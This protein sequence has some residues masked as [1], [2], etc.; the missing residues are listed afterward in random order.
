MKS[1]N[2]NDRPSPLMT[3]R[4]SCR[5][6]LSLMLA[7]LCASCAGGQ[8][9]SP[10]P[11]GEKCLE[12]GNTA[13]PFTLDPSRANLVTESTILYDM[14]V[15]LTTY[16]GKGRTVPGM[17]V[18]WTTSQD[19]LTWTFTLRKANWSDGVPVTATDFVTAFR[20]IQDPA[21]ASPYSY[22]YYLIVGTEAVNAGKARPETIGAFAPSPQTLVLKLTHPAPYLA[23]LLAHSSALPLPRHVIARWGDKWVEPAHYVT[24]GAYTLQFWK[25]GDRIVLRKNPQFVD[26]HSVCFDQVSYY[27]TTDPVSA[28]RRVASG[29]LDMINYSVQSRAKYRSQHM[30]GYDRPNPILSTYYVAFNLQVPQLTDRRVRLALSMAIDREFMASKLLGA[31]VTPL[32][33][34]TPPGLP[35]YEQ[36]ATPIWAAWPFERRIAA[37][38]E[39][40]RRVGYTADHPLTLEFKYATSGGRSGIAALQAD[41][42]RI[43]ADISLAPAELQI[44]YSELNV[45]AY[46]IALA[47]WTADYADASTYLDL[48][49]KSSGQQ[50]YTGYDNPAYAGLAAQATQERDGQKRISILRRSEAL[51]MADWPV[52]PLYTD[53][54]SYL[55][56]PRITGFTPNAAD[57]HL[58]RYMCERPR[59]PASPTS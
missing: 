51:A 12:V 20:R 35:G 41:W 38:Q 39:L 14:M 32:Y 47:G 6:W 53:S 42:R 2:A 29:E 25:L 50:N 52:A 44:H 48:F 56:N 31:G 55:V 7:F 8:G 24:N 18:A 30:P 15:G 13:E 28:E 23:Q 49:L 45:K 17:A 1:R 40:M 36:I 16:D 46:Q 57:W 4:K 43:G 10:C 54:S 33:G 27:P 9:R 3:S 58:K 37:A 22:L 11:N 34:F 59:Q 19:G 5:L 26:V 21:T